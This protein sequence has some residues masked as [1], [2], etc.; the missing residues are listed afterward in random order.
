MEEA[1]K[2][3]SESKN[4]LK[5]SDFN[6]FIESDEFNNL[7][8]ESRK[9]I[10]FM[11]AFLMSTFEY[12]E[13]RKCVEDFNLIISNVKYNEYL[14]DTHECY[15]KLISN[16]LNIIG[17]LLRP[18]FRNDQEEFINILNDFVDNLKDI[19]FKDEETK[20]NTINELKNIQDI[21]SGFNN[22]IEGD[23]K[24]RFSR[25]CEQLNSYIKK[26]ENE[27]NYKIMQKKD[28]DKDY[29]LNKINKNNDNYI[30]T[31]ENKKIN[32]IN[33]KDDNINNNQINYFENNFNNKKINNN[34][35]EYINEDNEEFKIIDNNDINEIKDSRNN[36]FNSRIYYD[37]IIM[38]F[39]ISAKINEIV[40]D[41]D[42]E[43]EEEEKVQEIYNELDNF[44]E[45]LSPIFNSDNND[46][47]INFKKRYLK[48]EDSNNIKNNNI[49]I[50]INISNNQNNNSQI[51]IN[52]STKPKKKK[53]KKKKKK[54]VN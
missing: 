39:S 17:D 31:S 34:S 32:I 36:L 8:E 14:C 6:D 41:E 48:S 26:Q 52:N 23:Y 50:S 11:K 20:K 9:D 10:F 1:L 4:F 16:Y 49:N 30:K 38:D 7:N 43:E 25:Y 21:L 54:D 35:F 46:D 24:L 13:L 42:G 53:K 51:N 12:E 28:K 40:N 22:K 45:K 29:E 2:F 3:I 33:N 44:I 27:N 47:I 19:Y 5:S 18:C 15:E 37:S